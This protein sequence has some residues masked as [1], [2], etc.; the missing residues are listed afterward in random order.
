MVFSVCD[1][2][3]SAVPAPVVLFVDDAAVSLEQS[4]ALRANSWLAA[5]LLPAR[6]ATE[7]GGQQNYRLT[8]TGMSC[9]TPSPSSA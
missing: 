4:G 7:Q 1:V 2:A 8:R 3:E 6:S 9:G 5:A